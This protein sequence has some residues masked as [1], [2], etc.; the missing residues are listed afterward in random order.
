MPRRMDRPEPL[1]VD[2][3]RRTRWQWITDDPD[4]LLRS[5]WQDSKRGR[6]TCSACSCDAPAA[7]EVTRPHGRWGTWTRALCLHHAI[8]GRRRWLP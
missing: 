2:G 3:R 5:G 8:I 7:V 6:G 4:D 1:A